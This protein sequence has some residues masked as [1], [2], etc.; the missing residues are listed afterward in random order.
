MSGLLSLLGLGL[1]GLVCGLVAW[2][3]RKKPAPLAPPPV[4]AAPHWRTVLEEAR[5]SGRT[6]TDAEIRVVEREYENRKVNLP[7]NDDEA[8]IELMQLKRELAEMK[9]R[10]RS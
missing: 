3:T 9:A 6:M 5:T 2:F 10:I 4:K 7:K 1:G 8:R